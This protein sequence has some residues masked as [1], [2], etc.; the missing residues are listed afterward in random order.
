MKLLP[1]AKRLPLFR[2]IGFTVL[3]FTAIASCNLLKADEIDAS[4]LEFFESKVRPLLIAHCYECHS[5]DAAKAENLQGGLRLDNRAGVQQGGESGPIVVPG[6]PEDSVLIKSVRY[7][8]K[9]L[10]MPPKEPLSADQ[11]A[12]LEKWVAMGTPDPRD[13]SA[14]I[15]S[16]K[17]G[18]D[19]TEAR[20]LWAFQTPVK[21]QLPS[22]MNSSWPKRP[23]DHFILAALE[24]RSLQPVRPAT[25]QELIRRATFDLIG[26]PPTPEECAEFENDIEPGAWERVVQRLLNSPHYGERW[27]RYW[28]DVARYADDQGNSFLTPTPAA[29]LY[30][31]WVVKALNDDMP[32]DEF[33]RLQIAGDEMPGPASDYIT[34]LAGLGFQ[35]L[36]P[37][38]RKG[39]AGEAKAKADELEDRVDTLSRGILGLTVSCARCHDH[40]FDPIPTRDYYSLA[41]AYNG[42]EWPNRM[43][44]AP[45]VVDAHN[46]WRGQVDQQT[47]ALKKWK[48]DQAKAVGRAG[49]EHIEQ[50]VE[51]ACTLLTQRK[52]NPQID[53]VALAQQQSLQSHFVNR[54]AKVIEEASEESL[55]KKLRDITLQAK[56][57]E[58]AGANALIKQHAIDFKNGVQAALDA[59]RIG[60]QLAQDPPQP[61]AALAPE[62]EKLL[63]QLWKDVK[64]PFFVAESEVPSLLA[65]PEKQHLAT[66][67][68]QLETLAASP[69]P[70][71]PTMPSI[72]GGGQAMQVFVRGNPEKLGE[73]APPGFLQVLGPSEQPRSG[74]T[75]SRLELANEITS[76]ENPLTARVF[77]NR[78]WHYHFGRGIVPTLSNFGKLGGPPSHPELLDTLAAQ[79]V[80]SGWSVKSLHR[81][82]MLSATYQ[83]SS[84]QQADNLLI[85]P[86]NEYLWRITPRRLDI[87]AWRDALL[88]VSGAIDPLIGGPS[89]DQ[90]TP[91]VKEVEGFNFFSRLNGF[92]ADNPAGRRR[93]LYTVVSRYAP[94]TTMTLFDFPEPNVTSDQRNVTTVPQQQLF[95]L[96][97]PFMLE[98]SREFAKRLEQ[99]AST[100]V[101]R[102]RI[103]WQL[104]YS[105]PPTDAELAVAVDFL[106]SPTETTTKDQLNRWQQLAHAIL[107]SNE[108]MFLP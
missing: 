93:T 107:A 79:F 54:W 5:E 65:E 50:Y 67:Q 37:Q 91:G 85:D 14:E 84:E 97:G 23:L 100:D 33:V 48:E 2:A 104:A 24:Q 32:Y 64:A 72:S 49:L 61:V 76:P 103:A 30:R 77:V 46:Q 21:H 12:I 58:P 102:I 26:L 59:L 1:Y 3:G 96:N 29:Y 7:A 39:A 40:K 8:D 56:D 88:S 53:E 47:A 11:V 31:D 60:E 34:R 68:M 38:F 27:G 51:A 57:M 89:V 78:V 20:K 86:S 9:T 19:F 106:Q 74:K 55:Y 69:P 71:G 87:E 92:E 6:K 90:V 108:F 82:I 15:A 83:L 18:I 25:R 41:A 95:V 80:E 10:Q 16:M 101:E 4:S 17:R 73:P 63:T 45:E 62:H 52:L 75:F 22:V 13:G 44:A 70:S 42:A 35:S 105:R 43:L 28:L 94:N 98:M 66:L 36:G 99:V 81:E